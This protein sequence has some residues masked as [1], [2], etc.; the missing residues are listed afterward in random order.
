MS[1]EMILAIATAVEMFTRNLLRDIDAMSEEQQDAF[2]AEQKVR[3]M[4]HDQWLR[5]RMNR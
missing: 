2:I 3:K 4:D 1:P 5:E